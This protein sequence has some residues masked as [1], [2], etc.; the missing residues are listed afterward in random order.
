MKLILNLLLLLIAFAFVRRAIRRFLA[1]AADQTPP[2]DPPGGWKEPGQQ[3][4]GH[5]AFDEKQEVI[6]DAEFEELD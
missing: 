6:E 3:S 4:G 5:P 1:P 2:Q